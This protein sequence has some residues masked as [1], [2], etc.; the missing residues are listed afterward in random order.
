[1]RA[2]KFY[3]P[4]VWILAAVVVAA[5]VLGT[6]SPTPLWG[7]NA[8]AFLPRAMLIV[9]CAALVMVL[10]LAF[11][12]GPAVDRALDA[13]PR[14]PVAPWL[15]L[16]AVVVSFLIFWFFREGHTLLGDGSPLTRSL[17][18]G[19]RFH[20]YQ[21]LTFVLHQWFYGLTRGLFANAAPAEV[22]RATVGLSSALCGAL[23]VPVA[24]GLS[25]ELAGERS[26]VALTFV[27]ILAQGYVQLFFGYVEN[28]T[29]NALVLGAYLLTALRFVRGSAPLALPAMALAI[30]VGLD[31]SAVLLVPSFMVL[32]V[33]GLRRSPGRALRDVAIMAVVVVAIAAL[34]ARIQPGY[35]LI[36]TAYG[37]VHQAL[38]AH[39]DQARSLAYMFSWEHVRDFKNA[40]MLIGPAAAFLFVAGLVWVAISRALPA[41]TAFVLA[42]GVVA[43]GG[44]WVT[45]DL[46]LGYPRDWDLFAP[47]G[48]AL[49][50]AGLGIAL[51]GA[52][53]PDA[54]RRWLLVLAAV[55]LFHTV[56]WIAVNTSFDRSFERF[57]TLPLGLG[58]TESAVG[59]W[60][61]SHG[62]T[63][64]A[65]PWFQRS[66]EAYPANNVAAYRLGE[67]AMR[68]GM[69]PEAAHAFSVALTSRPD[70]DLY[71]F[72][73][74]DAIVRGGGEARW[75][76]A[77]ADTLLAKSPDEPL[78]WAALGVLC[79][80]TGE[81]DGAVTAF[82]RARA[83][84]PG[85]TVFVRLRRRVDEP[86]AYARAV[87]HDWPLLAGE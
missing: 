6:R 60:Y 58:R 4:A 11:R 83:L 32:L 38:F 67:I 41:A 85:D 15:G 17:P 33:I 27:T 30:N 50:A 18:Q 39:G 24:W 63:T 48:L 86:D 69:Y 56:P 77:H 42:V 65:I 44:A 21:P 26:A 12:R 87:A 45:T 71:R 84:A 5:H 72:A 40:Q 68:R 16:A 62:D 31:L 80:G 2:E 78:Y 43:L 81:R 51:S 8:Y 19:Q 20:P 54:L 57:K 82:E 22:A 35:S 7:A 28:Y 1:M 25:R 61:L 36:A 13:L 3:W 47:S 46:G 76:R 66:I 55:S 59:A 74:I 79:L 64:Q 9:A 53:R 10:A 37:I 49:T 14:P 70:K 73:L 75:A 23:F 34:M 29:F 52:W